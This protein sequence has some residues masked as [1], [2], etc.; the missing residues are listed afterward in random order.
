MSWKT[1]WMKIQKIY[2]HACTDRKGELCA[3]CRWVRMK[4]AA[5]LEAEE[6][7]RDQTQSAD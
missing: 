5:T 2:P 6:P 4:Y 1:S 3:I 7:R